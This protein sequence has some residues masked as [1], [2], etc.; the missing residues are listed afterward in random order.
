MVL[1]LRTDRGFGKFSAETYKPDQCIRQ[2]P[3]PLAG[4][5]TGTVTSF[6]F[7]GPAFAAQQL[8]T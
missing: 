8:T 7:L 5:N 4:R 1:A 6:V 2:V 3:C